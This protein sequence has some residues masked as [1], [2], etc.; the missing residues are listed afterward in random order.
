MTILTDKSAFVFADRDSIK[1]LAHAVNAAAYGEVGCAL[2]AITE[3]RRLSRLETESSEDD[4]FSALSTA[5]H[6]YLTSCLEYKVK[7]D[8]KTAQSFVYV[9][10]NVDSKV[11]KIGYTK[12]LKTRLGQLQTACSHKL[13]ILK[14]VEGGKDKECQIHLDLKDCRLNGEW[15]KWNEFVESY[16]NSL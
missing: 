13:V 4:V 8:A 14:T 9:I 16:V 12:D 7:E 11:V 3:A 2:A 5:V 1:K 6:A 15:F 10:Q